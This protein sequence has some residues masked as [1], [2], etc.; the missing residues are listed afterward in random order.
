MK[1]KL[2]ILFIYNFFILVTHLSAVHL[3]DCDL[4]GFTND[5]DQPQDYHLPPGKVI[6]GVE[7]IHDNGAEYV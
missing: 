4:T 3:I 5:Y 7:S 2:S 6:K 1:W